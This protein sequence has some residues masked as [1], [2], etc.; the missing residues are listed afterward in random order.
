MFKKVSKFLQ[1]VRQEMAKVSWPSRE[2][3]K[4]TTIVVI[5]ITLILST[6]I[7]GVDKILQVLLNFIY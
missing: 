1:E 7:L 4:G 2:E 5:V 3:L 6:Y